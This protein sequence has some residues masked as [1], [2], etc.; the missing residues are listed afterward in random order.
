MTT[1]YHYTESGLDNVFLATGFEYVNLPSG[2]HV[3]IKD[4]EGLHVAI[5]KALIN[6]KKNL[7]GREIRFLRQEMLLS[8]ANLAKLLEV[9]EQT[10]HR[11]ETAKTDIPKPAESLIRCLYDE[12]IENTKGL[13]IRQRLERIADLEDEI[14]GQKLTATVKKGKWQLELDLAA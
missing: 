10:V 7:T 9:N 2:R 1:H 13:N 12:Q 4:I 14:D 6:Q 3:R 8:Q 5:G 11:W